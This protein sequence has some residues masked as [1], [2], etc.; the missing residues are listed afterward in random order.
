MA[1]PAYASPEQLRNEAVTTSCDIYALGA[2]LFELL[3]GTRPGNKASAAAM[4][5]R[6]I[7]SR[8]RS[9]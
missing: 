1:T 4:I 3:A 2:I 5:E 9:D 6:A 7:W 8:S